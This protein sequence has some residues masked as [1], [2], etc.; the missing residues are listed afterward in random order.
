MIRGEIEFV[1][2]FH[3]KFFGGNVIEKGV[4]RKRFTPFSE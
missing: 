3:L 2:A 4:N 1:A